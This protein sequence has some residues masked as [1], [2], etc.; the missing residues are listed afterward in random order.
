MELLSQVFDY[1]FS[2]GDLGVAHFEECRR[3]PGLKI[4]G[5]VKH[6]CM[7]VLDR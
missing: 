2:E 6:D 1:V 5:L 4:L 7:C 3:R